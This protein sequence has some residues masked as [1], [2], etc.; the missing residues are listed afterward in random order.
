ME[1]ARTDG[2]HVMSLV[3]EHDAVRTA[4]VWAP[5][6]V[7]AVQDAVRGAAAMRMPLR[8]VGLGTWM[9]AGPPTSSDARPLRLGALN[10]VTQY[11]PG[12][13]TLTARAGTPLATIEAATASE[14]QWLPLDPFSVAD[15]GG[16]IGA[17]VA[18]AS[19]GPLAHAMGLPRDIVL[20]VEAVT[21]DGAVIRGG[22]R[23]VKNVAGFDLTRLLTGAWG[24]LG[25]LTEV[26]VR[27]RGRPVRDETVAII[28]RRRRTA[29]GQPSSSADPVDEIVRAL[30]GVAAAPIALELVN[31]RLATHLEVTDAADGLVLLAR[32]A[33]N[34]ERVAA[35]RAALGAVGDVI[36][37]PP[38]VWTALRRA[39]LA[40]PG[41]AAVLRWSQLPGR[42]ASTWR[43]ATAACEPFA[44]ALVHASIGR[45]IVRGIIPHPE[46][47]ALAAAI[48]E[49][50]ALS[51]SPTRVGEERTTDGFAG[52]CVPER[53][54]QWLWGA[55]G[56]RVMS[57]PLSRRVR[58]AFDPAHVLNP[59]LMDEVRGHV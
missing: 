19:A 17:T 4:D 8:I 42:L 13:L 2:K 52:T 51:R 23:V 15:H 49:D 37:V 31:R 22:G 33:G 10:G 41:P 40:I 53:L 57:D 36:T 14:G 43:H 21:G 38:T 27:L 7:G 20:G 56:A 55:V 12:D 3:Q 11:T 50:A 28:R 24:T 32:L 45:G 58:Q 59:G 16:S 54:P 1:D 9:D 46:S 44:D 48:A 5:D 6:T 34:A 47:A 29:R 25:I 30:R 39:E 35:E 26:T 18:T